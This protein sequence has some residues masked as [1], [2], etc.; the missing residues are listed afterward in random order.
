MHYRCQQLGMIAS[1]LFAFVVGRPTGAGAQEVALAGRGPRFLFAAT[2]KAAPKPL[3]LRSAP[4]LRKEIVLQLDGATLPEALSAIT[5]ETGLAFVYGL[6]LLPAEGRVSLRAEQITVAAAL[7][8]ILLD[9]GVDVLLSSSHQAALVRRVEARIAQPGSIVGRVTDAKTQAVLA[10]ATVV[11]Q[12]TAHS[13]TTGSDGR[14]R[15]AA[16]APGTYTVRARY[17]GYAPGSASVTVSADQEATADLALDK[18]AQRL[19]EVVTTGTVVPTEVKALPTPISVVTG[20]EIQQKGYQRVD[21]IFRGDVPGAIAWDRGAYNWYSDINVRGTSSLGTSYVKTYID[22]VEVADPL[23]VATIDPSSI[24]RIEIL[25]GPQGST[26]YGSDAAGGVMQI[27]T[28]QGLVNT[29]HPQVDAK[30]SAGVIESRWNSTVQQD[31]SLAVAGGTSDFSYRFGGGL[32]H[33]GDWTPEL[34]STNG[35]LNGSVRGTQGPVTAQLSARYDAE[36]FN[37]PWSQDFVSLGGSFSKPRDERDNFRQQT[38]GLTVAYALTPRWR[39]NLVLGYDRTMYDD[40]RNHPQLTTPA[41]TFLFVNSSDETKASVAYNTTYEASFG[42]ALR[43]SLTAGVDHWTYQQGGF[44][45]SNTTSNINT[46]PLPDYGNRY[47]YANTGYFAQEQL[48]LWD[49]LFVTAGLRAED[50]QNYGTDFGLAWSPR[51]GVSYV[52]TAGDV[53]VKTRVAYG[54]ATRPPIPGEAAASF[55]PFANYLAN[56]NLGPE[57]QRGWDGG[58]ELYFGGRGSLEATYYNQTAVDLIDVVL[59]DATTTPASYQYQNVGEI[60]NTG[61]EFQ[62]RLNEG[63]FS[64]AGTFSIANSVVQKLSPTYSGVLQIGDQMLHIPK[65]TAGATLSYSLP[66]T[67]VTLGMTYVDSWTEVDW[68]SFF[69]FIFGVH[70]YRGSFRNYWMTYPSFTKF[71]LAATQ[72]LT[73]RLSAFVRSDNLTNKTCTSVTT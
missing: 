50:N 64:L 18:S 8:Q 35:S 7:T 43:S 57:L 56:P 27:F 9:A 33:Y 44:S 3:D 48:G 60:K 37:V 22:G 6:D 66:R 20:D 51:V 71:N 63:P 28:K 40:Y 17:I 67:T 4:V 25:R 58:L 16:V 23:Y 13:A 5:R 53:T 14:Y 10:G 31:H 24:E 21:Q 26:I 36:S 15:I 2:P 69:G 52:H 38:Y 19:D 72:V 42:R 46:I 65:H 11:V 39:H 73:N 47:Q 70:P 29:S 61:W 49:A 68:V 45:A 41:D 1:I 30:V 54:K 62:G 34:R 55:T 59:L 32:T 12:G